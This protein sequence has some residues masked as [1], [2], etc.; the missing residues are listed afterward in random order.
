[1]RKRIT[2]IALVAAATILAF[3]PS[4]QQE[5]IQPRIKLYQ[6]ENLVS[7]SLK[8]EELVMP[9]GQ[10]PVTL[11]DTIDGDTIKIRVQGKNETVRYLLIDTPES[12]KPKMCVQPYAKESFLRN[13]ELVK[14][15]ALT[16][17][18]EQENRR[19][20]YGRLVAYVYVDGQSVQETLLKEGYARV[21][22]IM[23]PPYKYL[24][25]YREDEKLAKRS[26]LNIWSQPDFVTQWG[27]NGCVP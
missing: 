14:S 1:M 25:L 6:D 16:M 9:T 19:D 24:T 20:S 3:Q 23:N 5:E 12:K 13:D 10:I 26:K 22:Y 11:V 15:G 18:M 4:P 21:G 17:E 27:F 7:T 2:G 8:G